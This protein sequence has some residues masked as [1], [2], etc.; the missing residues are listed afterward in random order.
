MKIFKRITA[1]VLVALFAFSPLMGGALNLFGFA[2]DD[3]I[4]S[5]ILPIVPSDPEEDL[6]I[7]YMFDDEELTAKVI[8]FTDAAATFVVI[9]KEV[10]D[11]EKT[12]VVNII[13]GAA[14]S[15]ASELVNVVIPETV[16]TI[17]TYAFDACAKL[18]NVWFEGDKATFT[19]INIADGND[20]LINAQIHFGA[21]MESAGP[22]FVHVYDDHKDA[23]CNAC[24]KARAVGDDFVYGD[25]DKDEEITVEDAIY[26]LYHVN[27][28]GKYPVTQDVDYDKSGE[29]DLEDVFYLLYHLN[30]PER[31]P[32]N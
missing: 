13:A 22:A 12:Y 8:D 32:L 15:A 1:I 16:K 30:F 19:Q 20:D 17:E 26:L 27:F 21:C 18:E 31:Y 9:P 14:F 10:K 11:G 24:G 5:P 3:M 28:S 4:E 6:G 7:V 23:E 25:L 2:V 29:V